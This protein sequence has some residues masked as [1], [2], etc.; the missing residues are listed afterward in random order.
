MEESYSQADQWSP[1][2]INDMS[3]GVPQHPTLVSN[4]AVLAWP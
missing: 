3:R 2:H 4:I 1:L